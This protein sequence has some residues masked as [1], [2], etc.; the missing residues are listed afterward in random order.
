MTFFDT[1]VLVY[2]SIDQGTDKLEVSTRL[3]TEA[4]ENDTF[5]ISPLILS[6]YIFILSKLKIVEEQHEKVIFFSQFVEG[7]CGREN[8]LDAYLFCRKIDFCKNIN[9]VMHLRV[10]E[11]TC[12]RLLTFDADFRN[13]QKFTELPIE[14]LQ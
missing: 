6:E 7:D 11:Q 3:I 1:N 10:A 13:L 5:F 12:R 9:D 14:I 8:I 4:I 2:A